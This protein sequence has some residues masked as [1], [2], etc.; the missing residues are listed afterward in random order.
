MET[1]AV[2]E[3]SKGCDLK[4]C[5][6]LVEAQKKFDPILKDTN[7]PFY[8][9]KYATLDQVIAATQPHL[10]T[11]G[12]AIIQRNIQEGDRYGVFT[13]LV[14][15]ASGEE[16]LS[17]LLAK[18]KEDTIQQ[19][20]GV[21]TY[22]RRYEYH[23]ITG[24]ASEDDDGSLASGRTETE[25]PKRYPESA[26]RAQQSKPAPNTPPSAPAASQTHDTKVV[27]PVVPQ[28]S[29]EVPTP[30]E[31]AEIREPDAVPDARQYNEYANKAMS[32]L[33]SLEKAGLTSGAGLKSSKSKFKKYLCSVGGCKD[34]KELTHGRWDVIFTE[35]N[36][37]L[38]TPDG[39]KL[40]VSNI[41]AAGKEK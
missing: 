37:L 18:P 4:V 3:S 29:E 1:S 22:C 19:I 38:S 23:T 15:L 39:T 11:A 30:V 35:F 24:T 8:K 28:K 25:Q 13:R 9:S 21:L 41:E 27:A 40:A 36:K 12:I 5:A 17:S 26:Q 2:L 31:S 34:T 10:W 6:A 14:H 16:L 7:N 33:E 32:V 20:A